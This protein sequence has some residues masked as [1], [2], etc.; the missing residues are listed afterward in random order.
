MGNA[1]AG[2]NHSCISVVP[3]NPYARYNDSRILTVIHESLHFWLQ[4]FIDLGRP[5]T[6]LCVSGYNRS[7]TSTV[8]EKLIHGYTDFGLNKQQQQPANHH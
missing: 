7:R 1:F 3:E 2:Y 8:H 6:G 4:S 5:S